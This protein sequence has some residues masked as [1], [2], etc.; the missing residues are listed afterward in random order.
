MNLELTKSQGSMLL[1]VRTINELA[2]S[3]ELNDELGTNFESASDVYAQLYENDRKD[4]LNILWGIL[5]LAELGCVCTNIT[6]KDL[7]QVEEMEDFFLIDDMNVRITQKGK[8]ALEEFLARKYK[9][10]IEYIKKILIAFQPLA[11]SILD[12]IGKKMC[13]T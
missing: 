13:H 1:L 4:T 7:E 8:D 2:E 10:A 11:P 5:E 9:I 12:W 3:N 6:E